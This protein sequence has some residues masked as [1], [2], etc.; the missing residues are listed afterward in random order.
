MKNLSF[1]TILAFSAGIFVL[2]SCKKD[3]SSKDLLTGQS[4][5][6]IVKQ[7]SRIDSSDPWTTDVT[8]SCIADNCL[9]FSADGKTST[10][11]G[12]TKCDP[13]DPQTLA[14]T[15][16]LSEDGKTLTITQDGFSLPF[17]VEELT[18]SKLVVTASFL[19]EVRTT[20]EAK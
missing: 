1:L 9:S 10:D 6:K 2:A 11:E 8:E 18:S 12:A 19:G 7:E 14:G 16:V 3:D 13:A 20:F 17:V 15:Y 4:C 5:W